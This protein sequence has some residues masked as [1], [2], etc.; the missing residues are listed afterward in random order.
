M[1]R[2]I[3]TTVLRVALVGVLL[4]GGLPAP[5]VQARKPGASQQGRDLTPQQAAAKARAM[6]GGTVLKV[7]RKNGAYLVRLLLDSGRVVTVR[8]EG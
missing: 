5:E 6:H 3:P 8:I 7:T 1:S 2:C 4:L